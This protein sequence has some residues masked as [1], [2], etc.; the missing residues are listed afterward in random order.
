MEIEMSGAAWLGELEPDDAI[1]EDMRT[2][3]MTLA[4][5]PGTTIRIHFASDL[6]DEVERLAIVVRSFVEL[7]QEPQRG[8]AQR[9][10]ANYLYVHKWVSRVYGPDVV[11]NIPRLTSPDEVWEHISVLSAEVTREENGEWYAIVEA[12]C[13]WEV[14]HG[15]Q[16][17]YRNGNELTRV[18]QFDGHPDG[19]DDA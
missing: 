16:L 11:S 9:M 14:E 17:V 8:A 7:A 6:M 15:L 13:A 19:P 18:S 10:Y 2:R 1:P 12:N 4:S 5:F 3:P